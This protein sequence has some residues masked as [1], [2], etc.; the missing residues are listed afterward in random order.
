MFCAES[1]QLV[2]KEFGV[3]CLQDYVLKDSC[4]RIF[5]LVKSIFTMENLRLINDQS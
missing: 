5:R 4:D 3:V 1:W 2:D